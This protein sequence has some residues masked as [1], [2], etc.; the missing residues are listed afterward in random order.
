MKAKRGTSIILVVNLLCLVIPLNVWA[1]VA[2][3]EVIITGLATINGIK[4]TSGNTIFSDSEINTL[5]SG[6]AIVNFRQG[7]GTI[8]IE[9]NTRI[10]LSG[11][12][13]N[14]LAR[15]SRGA[16]TLRTKSPAEVATP[17]VKIQSGGDSVYSVTVSGNNTE[18]HALAR[19]VRVIAPKG[20]TVVPPGERYASRLGS[21]VNSRGQQLGQIMFSEIDADQGA[22]DTMEFIELYDSGFGDTPL[23]GFVVV[24]YDGKTDTVYAAFDLAG[25]VTNGQGYF[26]LGNAAVR[27]VGLIFPDNTL[28]DGPAAVALYQGKAAD[29]PPGSPLTFTNLGDAIVYS[30]NESR[31]DGLLKLLNQNQPQVNENSLGNSS[32]YSNQRCNL[33]SC[34][35]RDT[36]GYVQAP[37]TPGGE[38]DCPVAAEQRE[39]PPRRSRL[40][41]FLWPLLAGGIGLPLAL[42][43]AQG[44]DTPPLSPTTPRR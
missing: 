22:N 4:A 17:H 20:V 35:P 9:S 14:L 37:P 23:D 25:R 32:S 3:G 16:V 29:F 44:D 24:L 34:N 1:R 39:A 40:L 41:A 2:L 18:V 5:R 33:F 15:L 36:D 43:V 27:G 6:A 8:V 7:G 38:N 19:P 21:P 11:Q 13:E 42:S 30:N 10:S 28:R 12:P 26:V 31:D